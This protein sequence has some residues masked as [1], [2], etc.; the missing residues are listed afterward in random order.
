MVT[1]SPSGW[2]NSGGHFASRYIHRPWGGKLIKYVPNQLDKDEKKYLFVNK[3]RHLV[4][5]L[6][7][8]YKHFW[9]FVKCIFTILLM[10]M[11][12]CHRLG[13]S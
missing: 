7:T 11:A 5:T 3:K 4:G 13:F 1:V 8:I 2:V 6:F 10:L 12:S 9:D